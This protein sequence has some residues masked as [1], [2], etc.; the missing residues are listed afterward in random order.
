MPSAPPAPAAAP[1]APPAAPAPP[2]PTAPPAPPTPPTPPAP[3]AAPEPAE[4]T[5]GTREPEPTP[6]DER[7]PVSAEPVDEPT[8]EP[9]EAESAAST[10]AD[11]EEAAEAAEAS[12]AM[13]SDVDAELDEDSIDEL[14]RTI[15]APRHE[16]RVEW[17]LIDGNGTRVQLEQFAVVGRR[18][19]KPAELAAVQLIALPDP[20][21][22][23]SKTHALIEV[24]E[25]GAWVTDLGSTNGTELIENGTNRECA[26][27][28]RVAVPAGARL[29]FGSVEIELVR[30][31]TE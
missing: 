2:A 15:V 11:V 29:Q 1:P 24:G 16:T 6:D 10:E 27:D 7:A 4:A 9:V 31:E 13:P 20:E 22:M 8:D 23:L 30:E 18:P 14:D 19:A 25:D 21:K 26:A 17:T 3:S 28:E 5:T 12:E